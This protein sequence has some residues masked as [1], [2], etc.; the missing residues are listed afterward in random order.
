M[1]GVSILAFFLLSFLFSFTIPHSIRSFSNPASLAIS[2]DGESPARHERSR[3]SLGESLLP[4]HT[5]FW[6]VLCEL[7]RRAELG[8]KIF[9]CYDEQ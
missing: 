2:G 5:R 9:G 1:V 4:I 3:T 8:F 7:K 6:S